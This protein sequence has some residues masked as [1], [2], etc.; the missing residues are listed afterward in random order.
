MFQI[1]MILSLIPLEKF[2]KIMDVGFFY[3]LIYHLIH[4]ILKQKLEII[5]YQ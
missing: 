1:L 5:S 3:L 2:M 4:S